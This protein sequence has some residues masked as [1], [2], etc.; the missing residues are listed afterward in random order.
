MKVLRGA[1]LHSLPMQYSVE[2]G[3]LRRNIIMRGSPCED[4][5][6][7]EG[8]SY[9][10]ELTEH[11]LCKLLSSSKTGGEPI[12]WWNNV[13]RDGLGSQSDLKSS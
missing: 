2:G 10:A 1:R 4:S 13:L 9:D 7:S 12:I 8:D 6:L 5:L 3:E 11:V